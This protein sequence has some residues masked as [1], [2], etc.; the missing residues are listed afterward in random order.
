MRCPFCVENS[1]ESLV[2]PANNLKLSE[3]IEGYLDTHGVPVNPKAVALVY[4]CTNG[5]SFPLN[6]AVS[7]GHNNEGTKVIKLEESIVQ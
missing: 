1:E 4:G 7:N 5:H 3:T 2:F 6:E